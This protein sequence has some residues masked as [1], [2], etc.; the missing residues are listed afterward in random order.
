MHGVSEKRGPLVSAQVV[1]GESDDAAP[2][3]V[4][5]NPLEISTHQGHAI[6]T[7][8]HDQTNTAAE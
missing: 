3:P 4:S 6:C 7:A 8:Q 1:E 5:L 2:L